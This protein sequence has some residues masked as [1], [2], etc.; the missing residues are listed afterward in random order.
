MS[1]RDA[2][3]DEN[4]FKCEQESRLPRGVVDEIV[5]GQQDAEAGNTVPIEELRASIAL[6]LE[7]EIMTRGVNFEAGHEYHRLGESSIGWCS[8]GWAPKDGRPAGYITFAE[9]CVHVEAKR[10]D[11]ASNTD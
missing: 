7:G 4:S 1:E 2:K 5:R 8:C 10:T 6:P 11:C 3:Q 9:W